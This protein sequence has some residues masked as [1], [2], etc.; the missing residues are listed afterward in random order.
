M[1]RGSPHVS[2][3]PANDV[4]EHVVLS[5]EL[6]KLRHL[7]ERS[8][9]GPAAGR[10]VNLNHGDAAGVTIRKRVEQ[11]ILDDAENG[12]GGADPQRQVQDSEDRK[13][14]TVGE[15]AK[16]VSEILPQRLRTSR[17]SARRHPPL[18]AVPALT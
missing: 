15:T 13:R 5:L 14:G 11:D 1:P 6:E 10:V 7:E 16:P 8:A 2:I 17:P 4:I 18:E 3:R 12:G 9:A